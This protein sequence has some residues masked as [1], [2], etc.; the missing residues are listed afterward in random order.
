MVTYQI[1][2]TTKYTYSEPVPVCHNLVH[3]APRNLALQKC[4][5]FSLLLSPAPPY[6]QVSEDYFGNR[7][8]YFSIHVAH[9]GLTVTAHSRVELLNGRAEPDPLATPA[10][11]ALTR[12]VRADRSPAGLAVYQFAFGSAHIPLASEFAAFAQPCFPA[13]RPVLAGAVELM[14]RIHERFRYDPRATTISTSLSEVLRQRAGVC[15]DFAHLQIACLRALGLPARY[16]SGYL[17]TNA[18]AGQPRLVGADASHAWLA[19]WCGPLGWVD[20]DPTNNVVPSADHVTVA[21]GRD[22][23]D[24]CPIQGVVVGG[25]QHR[26][27]VAVDVTEC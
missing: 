4:H 18:P 13:G 20:L 3:L 26:M 16:V 27:S 22:Y 6:R 15:Q 1:T 9:L 21:W 7:V 2:H 11:D 19:V 8:D 5:E 10:W 24:V 25:G 17:R 12:E 23:A 14:A